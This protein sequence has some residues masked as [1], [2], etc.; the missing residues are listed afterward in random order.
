MS[1]DQRARVGESANAL[2]VARELATRLPMERPIVFFD[3]EATGLDVTMDRIVEISCVRVEPD[4]SARVLNS[5]VNPL[6]EIPADA[7]AVHGIANADAAQAPTFESLAAEIESF[8]AG[9]DLA[10]YN[11]GRYDLP[12]LEHEFA[13]AGIDF[14]WRERRLI[15]VSVIFRR[16]EP[17]SLTGAVRF[18]CSEDM[19]A[20][21][22]ATGDVAATMAVLVG[23][24]ERYPELPR[25]AVALDA[26]TRPRE[27]KR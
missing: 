5:L 22:T 27:R 17:R 12:L 7:I 18:Y 16:M 8:L 2:A 11:H 20:A 26:Y 9:A 15:D 23:Q 24:L 14:V 6:V 13:R 21:H 1:D 19:T 25:D 3:L 4:G 10:G